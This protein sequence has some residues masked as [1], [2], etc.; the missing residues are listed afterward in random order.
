MSICRRFW[1]ILGLTFRP[2]PGFWDKGQTIITILLIIAPSATPVL[3]SAQTDLLTINRG[4]EISAVMLILLLFV[5]SYQLQKQ[6]DDALDGTPK[7][8]CKGVASN[9][10]QPVQNSQTGQIYGTPVFYHLRVENMPTGKVDRH[11]A[12]K[13][14]GTVEMFDGSNHSLCPRKLH[15]WEQQPGPAEAGKSADLM[16]PLDIPPSGV[17]CKLDIGMKYTDENDFYTPTNESTQYLGFRDPRYKFGPGTYIASVR[18]S[19][20]NVDTLF[21]CKI[22]NGG[23]GQ[24]CKSI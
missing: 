20:E 19:G 4:L 1:R 3:T 8:V 5:A 22:I 9:A 15:R 12:R 7:L 18:L 14:A 17:E 13:I 2:I 21:H 24:G 23:R 10:N 6:L 11:T 16:Q